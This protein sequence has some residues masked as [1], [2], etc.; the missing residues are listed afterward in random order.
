MDN[1]KKLTKN[2][3]KAFSLIELSIVILVIGILVV[4]ITLGKTLVSKSRI[5]S[6]RS[7]TQSAPVI[8]VPDLEIWLESTL[9][10]SFIQSEASDNKP[11]TSWNNTSLTSGIKITAQG[12]GT[13]YSNTINGIHAI[14][15][16]GSDDNYLKIADA[17]FLNNTDY[18][19]FVL[20]QR[21][22]SK[23]NNYFLGDKNATT[24]DTKKLLLGYQDDGTILHSQAG[25][26]LTNNN[27]NAYQ[28]NLSAYT[29]ATNPKLYT[30]TQSSS[31]GKSTHID[32]ILAA[33]SSDK[34]Q[35]SGLSELAIGKGYDGEI[36]EIIIYTR[37][38]SNRERQGIESYLGK[39]LNIKKVATNIADNITCV[40]LNGNGT[41]TNSGCN[42][43]TIPCTV[44]IAGISETSVA[45]TAAEATL[46][47][48]S[49]THNGAVTYTCES[50][51][52]SSSGS[53]ASNCTAP[54]EFFA[55]KGFYQTASIPDNCTSVTIVASG[56][57]GGSGRKNNIINQNNAKGARIT[58]TKSNLSSGNSLY[59]FVGGKGSDAQMNTGSQGGWNGGGSGSYHYSSYNYFAGGG[60]GGA[61]NVSLDGTGLG[62]RIVVAGGSGGSGSGSGGN[63]GHGGCEKGGG[64]EGSI[65]AGGTQSKGGGSG[66]FGS[67]GDADNSSSSC[68]AGGGGG[69]YGG[70]GTSSC[71]SLGGGG[72]S[73]YAN[74]D[75]FDNCVE[76][77]NTGDGSVT[78]TWGN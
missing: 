41:I 15:F 51:S 30:F 7:L 45:Y 57:Q 27:I 19:I 36:A 6:A 47:C 40:T 39:K 76:D 49:T 56:A 24:L 69:W 9:D 25:N 61:S 10:K 58:Y 23:D 66:D 5:A 62:N 2:L 29:S 38:L 33:T 72:G 37:A 42:T 68:G 71:Q 44:N 4:G 59:I 73:S 18:T 21:L 12:Y 50:G 55:Y 16:N 77:T 34:T 11:I 13:T 54:K 31:L 8:A 26:V 28:S 52:L 67:G 60:G 20:E 63:G 3:R 48:D 14:K 35:L 46:T 22:S 65:N 70:T 53:C 74:G 43:N 78:L 17:S 1:D 64:N 75:E 32:G